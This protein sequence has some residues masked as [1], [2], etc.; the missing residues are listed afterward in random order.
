MGARSVNA[1][2]ADAF[3]RRGLLPAVRDSAIWWFDPGA[4]PPG[5]RGEQPEPGGAEDG[6]GARQPGRQPEPP[7]AG[8]P[9]VFAGHFAGLMIRADRLDLTDPALTS[10]TLGGGVI[11]QGQLEVILAERAVSLG[12]EIRRGTELTGLEPA[13]AGVTVEAGGQRITADWLVGCDGGRSAVRKLAGFGFAGLGPE[14]TGRQAL[15]D[16]AEPEAVP[17][18]DWV[19]TPAG[20]YVH[21][22]VPGRIHTVQY[23]SPPADPRAPVTA[24][25]LQASLREVSGID[26]AITRVHAATRYTDQTRQAGTYRRGRVLLAGDAAHVHSPAGGQGLNLG[27]GDAMNLGWKLAATVRGHA[28]AGLLDTYTAER[29]PVGAWVQLWSSAQTALGRPDPRSEALRTVVADL[30]DTTAGATYVLR[31]ISGLAQRYELPGDHPLTGRRAPEIVLA[32]GGTLAE[33]GRAGTALL[34]CFGAPAELAGLAELGAGWAGRL[35]VVEAAQRP[36]GRDKLSALLVRPDGYV[37]WAADGDPDPAA[38]AAALTTW[39]GP[40]A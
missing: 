13:A 5:P 21:G 31:Q 22:P 1:P 17:M 10:D 25:E 36:G 6:P 29:H 9:P 20:A 2:T 8:Q 35:R 32:G 33:A 28:P 30:L 18:G 34:A 14:F 16:L 39:L 19:R 4:G 12:A 26:T 37:A 24:A 11:S 40:A 7:Q 15:V 3:H 38:A 23:A 27:I